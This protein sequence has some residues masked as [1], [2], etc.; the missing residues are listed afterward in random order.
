MATKVTSGEHFRGNARWTNCF[1]SYGPR[2]D[3]RNGSKYALTTGL[4]GCSKSTIMDG[5]ERTVNFPDDHK[6]RGTRRLLPLETPRPISFVMDDLRDTMD[7][8]GC[9]PELWLA[10][11]WLATNWWEYALEAIIKLYYWIFH[12]FIINVYVS[13]YNC[14]LVPNMRFGGKPNY[15]CEIINNK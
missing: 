7:L 10:G 11:E 12:L 9:S 4:A 13:C 6:W 14:I 8:L 2:G 5:D 15:T 1:S 3:A